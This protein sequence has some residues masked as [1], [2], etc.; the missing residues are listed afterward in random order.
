MC[1]DPEQAEDLAIRLIMSGHQLALACHLLGLKSRATPQPYRL[2]PEDVDLIARQVAVE[3]TLGTQAAQTAC[4][5][6]K[7]TQ[8]YTG[9]VMGDRAVAGR[10][11]D[12]YPVYT[13]EEL[14]EIENHQG[15]RAA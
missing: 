2:H 8:R 13:A 5:A 7:G 1:C 12:P 9:T 4:S 14:D 6:S 11:H 3:L 10:T 15:G